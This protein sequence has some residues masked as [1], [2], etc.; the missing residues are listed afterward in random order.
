MATVG[1]SRE[2]R[3]RRRSDFVRAQKGSDFRVRAPAFLIAVLVRDRGDARLGLI[4]SKKLGGAVE[5]N[6]A[7]R[8]VRALFRSGPRGFAVDLIV[9]LHADVLTTAHDELER[10]WARA[11]REVQSRALAHGRKRAAGLARPRD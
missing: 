2:A 8:R 5:R 6:R 3:V 7:K 1:L 9:I 4:A 10:Q 11:V